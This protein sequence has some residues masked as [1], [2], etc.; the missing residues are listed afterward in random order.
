DLTGEKSIILRPGGISIEEIEKVIGTVEIKSES[1][2][3]TSPGQLPSHY[4]PK[5]PLKILRNYD[6]VKENIKCGLLAF[7]KPK[8]LKKFYKVEVL[9][10]KGDLVEAASNFFS[11]LHKLDNLGLDLIY[12]EPVPEKGLG[13][14]IMDRLKKAELKN[15]NLDK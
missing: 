6:E 1:E 3:I 14:A 2:K 15:S 11:L 12:V 4:S 10:E 9:S 13:I 5:T 8:N 7:K